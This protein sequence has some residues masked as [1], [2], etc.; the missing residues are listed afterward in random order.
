MSGRKLLDPTTYVNTLIKLQIPQNAGELSSSWRAVSASERTLQLI[1]YFV[2]APLRSTD[3]SSVSFPIIARP[4]LLVW[5]PFF[6]T[7]LRNETT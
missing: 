6:L 2:F 7:N 5:K 4:E 1:T 3:V